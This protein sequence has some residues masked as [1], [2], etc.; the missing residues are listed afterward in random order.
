MQSRSQSKLVEEFSNTKEITN[1]IQ[2]I[3]KSILKIKS[4]NIF[5]TKLNIKNISKGYFWL[6][7]WI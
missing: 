3:N 2:K 4:Q 1:V 6:I 7:H 5:Q